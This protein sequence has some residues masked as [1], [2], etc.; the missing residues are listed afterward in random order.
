MIPPILRTFRIGPLQ[1]S[2]CSEPDVVEICI[3]DGD[4]KLTEAQWRQ[5]GSLTAEYAAYSADFVRFA[6]LAQAELALTVTPD[7]DED[8]DPRYTG[9]EQI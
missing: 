2:E 8:L 6:K 3:P 9:F 1:I 7:P 4:C 5:L